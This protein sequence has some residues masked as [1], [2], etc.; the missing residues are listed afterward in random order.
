MNRTD[1]LTIHST[2]AN[3]HHLFKYRINLK[4]HPGAS[5][6]NGWRLLFLRTDVPVSRCPVYTKPSRVK[7]AGEDKCWVVCVW[8]G[9]GWC[10]GRVGGGGVRS[11]SK[12]PG[13]G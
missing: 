9:I 10:G 12:R 4:L 3:L 13:D 7:Q 8:R 2:A 1:V 5:G 11:Q 6:L